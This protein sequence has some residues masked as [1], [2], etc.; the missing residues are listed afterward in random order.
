M[1]KKSEEDGVQP[2]VDDIIDEHEEAGA[3]LLKMRELTHDY[4][5]P[6]DACNTY[7]KLFTYLQEME[8]DLHTHIHLENNI[9]LKKFDQRK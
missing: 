7:A 2:L 9:L 1:L 3:I 8:K 6:M 4:A 5:V